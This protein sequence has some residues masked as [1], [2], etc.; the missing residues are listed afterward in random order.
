[1][2][3][4]AERGCTEAADWCDISIAKEA[5]SR[6]HFSRHNPVNQC[7][8]IGDAMVPKAGVGLQVAYSV[9]SEFLGGTRRSRCTRA[10][11][12]AHATEGK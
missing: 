3:M 9:V 12:S 4:A 1:M 8:S 11:V 7:K 6:N 5:D 10:R 2:A